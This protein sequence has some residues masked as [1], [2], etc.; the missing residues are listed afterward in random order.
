MT[1]KVL[2]TAGAFRRLNN[3]GVACL[4]S[5][6]LTVQL[7]QG[8]GPMDEERLIAELEGCVAVVAGMEPYTERVFAARPELRVI[9]RWGIGYD[10]VDVAAATRHGVMLVNTP[11][12]VTEAVADM[13][14]ALMLGIARRLPYGDRSVRAGEWPTIFSG[15]VFGK[16]LGVVGLGQIGQAVIRRARGFSMRILGH[17]PYCEDGLCERLIIEEPTLEELLAESDFVTLHCTMCPD[18][19]HLINR[20]RLRLMKPTAYLI[21]A[22][23]G[24]LVDQA[25][26]AEAL[27]EGWIAGAAVDVLDPEPPDPND[28]LL[29]LDNIV[30]MPH[31]SS[32]TYDT[33]AKVN[34]RVCENLFEALSG[35]RPRFLVNAEM[36]T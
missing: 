29:Q 8:S 35:Q 22:G 14:L 5:K 6:G 28:P 30:F 15:Q 26:L 27:R 9:A 10:S 25:A 11:G 33:V 24:G 23:R 16:V 31:V 18:T 20:E 7:P 32:F 21:N 36:L 34:E 2:I 3:D 13:T 17:D 19:R 1:G 12:V 4:E